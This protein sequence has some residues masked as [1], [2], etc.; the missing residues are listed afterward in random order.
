MLVE[1]RGLA[2]GP[3]PLLS[4]VEVYVA[5]DQLELAREILLADAVD[6]AVD[7]QGIEAELA[8]SPFGLTS[9]E[10]AE[11]APSSRRERSNRVAGRIALAALAVVLVVAL[12]VGILAVVT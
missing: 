4:A 11:P 6:A 8:A 9:L 1:L 2:D 12:L 7:D 3:Y 10:A 5:A